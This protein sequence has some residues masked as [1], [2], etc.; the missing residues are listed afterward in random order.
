MTKY[1]AR[2]QKRNSGMMMKNLFRSALLL[3]AGLAFGGQAFRITPYVQ[4]PSTNAMTVKWCMQERGDGHLSWWKASEGSAPKRTLGKGNTRPRVAYELG[5]NPAETNYAK[6]YLPFT[7]PYQHRFRI[8]GLEPDTRY[9]YKVECGGCVYTNAFTT[10]PAG[11]RPIRFICYSDSETEPESTGAKVAWEDPADD[12]SKRRYFIDQTTGYASNIV[13]IL[14]RQPDFITISGDLAEKGSKQVDWDEFWRH[15]AG[16]LNDP[17]GSIPILA[18]PGNHDYHGYGEDAG[19]VGMRKYL[20]YF[21]FEPNDADVDHDQR[22]R[23]HRMDYGPAT[24]I[25][26]DLNN[27]PDGDPAKDTN[28]YMSDAECRA[29]DFNEGAAQ[30]RWLEAQLADAQE[31]S[32]FTF[33][34]SHQC[35]Y[36]VGYHGRVNGEKG[37]E[38]YGEELSGTAS[39]C[40]TPLLMRYGV[41]AWICG[42]DEIMER[43]VVKG[44]RVDGRGRK[45]AHSLLVYDVGNSGDGLRGRTRTE[46]PNPYE[47]YRAHVNSREIWKDGLLVDGGKHYGHLEVNV[48]TNATGKWEARFTPVY[49]FVSTNAAGQAVGFDRR[50]YDDEVIVDELLF[51]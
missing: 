9:C 2:L 44:T 35:P 14:R 16:E 50:V 47:A 8:T 45:C 42:H 22:Q 29:P 7:L 27:G 38:G 31:K 40:L 33:V 6:P 19:E 4:H 39:R 46:K 10:A 11:D 43:S 24:F 32:R 37:T 15:N 26:L 23:F 20:S 30:Y 5:Y 25:F 48:T 1:N 17:A 3:T 49:V 12:S 28:I 34:F 21:E 36:S 18:A 51:N 13:H 41:T